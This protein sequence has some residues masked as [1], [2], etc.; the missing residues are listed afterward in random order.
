MRP[1]AFRRPSSANPE[2]EANVAM[3]KTVCT[4]VGYRKVNKD[5]DETLS[6]LGT[7]SPVVNRTSLLDPLSSSA[8]QALFSATSMPTL[9]SGQLNMLNS[10]SMPELCSSVSN[11]GSATPD[12][13]A[14]TC[15]GVSSGS[16]TRLT[17][18][19]SLGS[20]DRASTVTG[21]SPE[22]VHVTLGTSGTVSN[23]GDPNPSPA[24]FSSD[25]SPSVSNEAVENGFVP[26]DSDEQDKT[27]DAGADN[28]EQVDFDCLA[29]S[30]SEALGEPEE[31]TLP[32]TDSVKSKHSAT[33]DSSVTVTARPGKGT[34]STPT[35]ADREGGSS[36]D[37]SLQQPQDVLLANEVLSDSEH[38]QYL[39]GQ[40]TVMELLK[41]EYDR[42]QQE[43]KKLQ[44]QQ[45]GGVSSSQLSLLQ[46]AVQRKPTA[47]GMAHLNGNRSLRKDNQSVL[48]SSSSSPELI[49][50]VR[51][52]RL[53]SPVPDKT[54]RCVYH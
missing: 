27:S 26:S 45:Q 16:H 13:L 34:G 10:G 15:S 32:R 23:N 35:K 24:I 49:D 52:H 29:Q 33:G 53:V 20:R 42:S 48:T 7:L 50:L 8:S 1:E 38:N 6:E 4:L 41:E 46:E 47:I 39:Q 18:H 30:L 21:A 3:D 22:Q 11:R 17:Q 37:V 19:L 31:A 28:P 14:L 40:C 54:I 9:G 36:L 44:Q 12:L 2:V 25:S 43:A 5:T 51:T